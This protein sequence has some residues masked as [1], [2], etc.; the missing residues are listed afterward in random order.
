MNDD[1]SVARRFLAAMTA[2][3]GVQADALGAL[4]HDDVAFLLLGRDARGAEPAMAALTSHAVADAYRG[5]RWH[6]PAA[7]PGG[8]RL[9]GERQAGTMDRGLIVTLHLREG[10]IVRLEQQRTPPPPVPAGPIDIPPEI[11]QMVDRAL[12]ERHPM[13]L[14]YTDPQGQPVLT[15]R[16]S[17]QV[18]A[19]DQLAMWIRSA[20]GAFIQAIARNPRVAMMYRNEDSKATYQFQG[21]ARVCEDEDVRRAVY[22]RSAYAE[23]AHDFA[24]L[25]VV[26]VIDLDRVEGYAGL[27]PEGQRGRVLMVRS[28]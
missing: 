6:E 16:G 13:L 21:R 10:R 26:V 12:V 24:K 5:L 28:P 27:G 7:V 3:A 18:L 4:L 14:A 1:L 9:I 22:E 20:D 15:F 2:A 19:K 8:V 11:R 23:Q 25:G 17:T